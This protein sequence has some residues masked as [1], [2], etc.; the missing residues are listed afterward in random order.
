MLA[1][2]V[3]LSPHRAG[4][5]GM[6]NGAKNT[7]YRHCVDSN[8]GDCP[9]MHRN[10]YSVAGCSIDGIIQVEHYGCTPSDILKKVAAPK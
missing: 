8:K 10:E 6:K 7:E 9:Y 1:K 2:K 4:G 5:E 3:S